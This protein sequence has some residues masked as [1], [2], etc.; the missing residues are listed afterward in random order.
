[1]ASS[2]DGISWSKIG[3]VGARCYGACFGNGYF[4]S[5][6]NSNNFYYSTDAVTWTKGTAPPGTYYDDDITYGAGKFLTTSDGPNVQ[7]LTDITGSW[8]SAGA[9]L[10]SVFSGDLNRLTYGAGKFLIY[11]PSSGKTALSPDGVTWT[12]ASTLKSCSAFYPALDYDDNMFVF[13]HGDGYVAYSEDGINWTYQGG[14]SATPLQTATNQKYWSGIA[15]GGEKWVAVNSSG[16]V[17]TT[18]GTETS[19]VST[20][21]LTTDAEGNYKMEMAD[22]STVSWAVF[23]HSVTETVDDIIVFADGTTSKNPCH[24]LSAS[25]SGSKNAMGLFV[26]SSSGGQLTVARPGSVALTVAPVLGTADNTFQFTSGPDTAAKTISGVQTM[27]IPTS[28][29]TKN[30]DSYSCSFAMGNIAL[31]KAKFTADSRVKYLAP[32]RP[33]MSRVVDFSVDDGGKPL[34][35]SGS[36]AYGESTSNLGKAGVEFDENLGYWVTK[37]SGV[38]GYIGESG[39]NQFFNKNIEG[40]F[41]C[42]MEDVGAAPPLVFWSDKN[43]FGSTVDAAGTRLKTARYLGGLSRMFMPFGVYH[44]NDYAWTNIYDCNAGVKEK[45]IY[46]GFTWPVNA[47]LYMGA[48][49]ETLHQ[50][51]WQGDDAGNISIAQASNASNACARVTK[52]ACDKLKADWGAN[53][54]IYVIRYRRQTSYRHKISGIEEPFDYSYLDDCASGSSYVYDAANEADLK[55]ALSTIAKDIKEFAGYVAAKNVE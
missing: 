35:G 36:V 33:E 14:S 12:A 24:Y 32:P 31:I 52:S 28:T 16:Y 7:V 44:P 17:A 8:S 30:G 25:V 15:Y 4:A 10:S 29:M 26:P 3:N 45:M 40:D 51:Q 34:F 27:T 50:Y 41:Y 6:A 39:Y 18:S 53:L 2:G 21:Q 54:R 47:V 22:G 42:L 11:N 9:N 43:N 5:L 55:S 46:G 1:V 49:G 13:L 37:D 19:A 20:S 23:H 48:S 38:M